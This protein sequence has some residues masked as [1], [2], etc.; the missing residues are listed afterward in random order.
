MLPHIYGTFL[1]ELFV[2]LAG[3]SVDFLGNQ[4]QTA[5]MRA[6]AN[7]HSEVVDL[8]LAKGAQILVKS[9]GISGK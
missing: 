1:S 7:G 4:K 8:L 2:F 6:S 9:V 5:L 3:A